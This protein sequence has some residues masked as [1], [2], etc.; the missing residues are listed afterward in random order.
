MSRIVVKSDQRCCSGAGS[1][2][3]GC[4]YDAQRR[5]RR[6]CSC[7]WI[8]ALIVGCAT[9]LAACGGGGS[10]PAPAPVASGA[11]VVTDCTIAAGASTCQAT[12]NWSSTAA[13]PRVLLAGA[14]VSTLIAGATVAAVGVERQTVGLFDGAQLLDEKSVVG[15]CT[16]ASVW[17]GSRCLAFATRTIERA[18]TPFVE[19]GLAITLEVV[20]YRPLG[21]GPFPLAIFHH[22]S[23]GNGDDP[24]LFRLTY[25]NESIARF[26]AER[27]WMVAFPQRRGRGASDGLYDEGFT[28]DRA[29]YSCLQAPAAAGIERALAD[30]D[31]ALE[32]L[33]T[34]AEVDAARVLSAGFSRGGLLAAVHAA[35]RPTAFRGVVNFVGG[36]LGEGCTD[37]V[38]VNRGS[39]VAA[40]AFPGAMAWLYGENDPFYSVAHTGANYDAFRAAGGQGT[41]S[42]YRRAAGLSGH[43]IINDPAL[44]S[45]ELDAYVRGLAN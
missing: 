31:A 8:A 44:W 3:A 2:R 5:I 22:G 28:P 36:W 27:G 34:R 33:R 14:T 42:V 17:D 40:A 15:T 26:F 29:R 16:A 37:A 10:S 7:H 25:T 18:S 30:T 45:S 43:L 32:W 35:R 1:A 11:L 13:A 41:L 24:S 39:F 19:G 12:I 21:N 38:A 20:V 9:L 4:G 6:S 23:T